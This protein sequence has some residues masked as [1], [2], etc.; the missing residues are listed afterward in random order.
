MGMDGG[1]EGE[2]GLL[3]LFYI[4]KKPVR[5]RGMDLKIHRVYNIFLT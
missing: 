5:D 4:P 1:G 3:H 2:G